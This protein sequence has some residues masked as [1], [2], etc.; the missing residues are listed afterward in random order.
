MQLPDSQVAVVEAA[1]A[2]EATAVDALAAAT[3]LPPETVTG[4]AF[5]LE[6]RGL[7]VVSERIDETISL[8]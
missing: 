4:A 6:E 1:N 3:D 7:V 8:T 2:D 5:E